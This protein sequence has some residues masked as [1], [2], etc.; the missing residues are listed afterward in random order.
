MA[1][2]TDEKFTHLVVG[3][4]EANAWLKKEKTHGQLLGSKEENTVCGEGLEVL[5]CLIQIASK[6]RVS[7]CSSC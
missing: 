2:A 3:N 6:T 4:R 7:L 1:L 5:N